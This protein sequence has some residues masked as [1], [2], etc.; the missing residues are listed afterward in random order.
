MDPSPAT[1]LYFFP[2][3]PRGFLPVAT[4]R[5][6]R[7]DM[8]SHRGLR[9]G[10]VRSRSRFLCRFGCVLKVSV[11]TGEASRLSSKELRDR[12]RKVFPL[13]DCPHAKART[14]CADSAS[15]GKTINLCSPR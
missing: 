6:L 13:H 14:H 2:L 10:S 4:L 8:S 15:L 11:S 12:V 7:R 5:R 1:S 9:L 3:S